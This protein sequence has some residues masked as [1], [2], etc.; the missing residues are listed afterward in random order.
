MLEKTL[1]DQEVEGSA[2]ESR[3][4]WLQLQA[5][6]SADWPWNADSVTQEKLSASVLLAFQLLIYRTEIK[7][8]PAP[9]PESEKKLNK[10]GKGLGRAPGLY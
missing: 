9:D 2:M 10:A 1:L 7:T 6:E 8:A 4:H 3:G 5:L